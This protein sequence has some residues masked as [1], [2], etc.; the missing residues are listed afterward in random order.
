[1]KP[2]NPRSSSR[3]PDE[4]AT[5]WWWVRHAPVPHLRHEIYGN[6]DVDCDTSDSSRFASLA[7]QLPKD[8]VWHVSHLKRTHQTAQAIAD[9][10]YPLPELLPSD[11]IGEQDF[12]DLHGRRHDEH[13]AARTDPF[14]GFWPTSPM[15][16]VPGGE[17]FEDLCARV[18]EFIR[19]GNA[20]YPGQDVVCVAHFGP[21]LAAL[22]LALD[23]NPSSAVAFSIPNLSVT[24]IHHYASV[25]TGAP[26][27][28]VYA[29]GG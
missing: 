18:H 15:D 2:K 9:Q 14:V 29:V 11:R 5:R 7:D 27:Y 25:P 20:K 19:A 6:R 10:G 23:L 3:L 4:A 17:H 26:A 8:A 21:I 22:R 24:R 1:M 28:R 13:A 12:G 16:A